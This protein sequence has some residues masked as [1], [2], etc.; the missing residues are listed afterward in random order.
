MIRLS[1]RDLEV[2]DRVVQMRSAARAHAFEV[3]SGAVREA[4]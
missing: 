2:A 4:V 1:L 3:A